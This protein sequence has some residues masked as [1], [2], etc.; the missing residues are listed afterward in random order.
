ML[1]VR[2]LHVRYFTPRGAIPAVDGVAFGVGRGEIVGLVGESGCGKTTV[3][4]AILQTVQTPGR[5]TQGEVR[6]N[7]KNLIGLSEKMLRRLRWRTLSLVPQ[8]AM[9]SLNP[10][11]RIR[12]QMAD[13]ILTHE[14]IGKAELDRRIVG[15]LRDVGLPERVV[16][17]YPHELSG[18]MKQRICIAMAI[19]LRPAAIVA[20][21]PTSSLDVVVQRVVVQTLLDVKTRLGVSLLVISHDM[22]IQA[23]L[24]DRIAVMYA[25]H[26]VETAPVEAA[27]ARPLHPYTQLLI[28]SIPSIRERSPVPVSE[29]LTDDL[30]NLPTGFV[31]QQRCGFVKPECHARRPSLTEIEKDHF[32]ACWMYEKFEG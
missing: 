19:A 21:E 1:E 17:L 14:H 3:A 11:L 12:E 8:G 7:G 30:R 23:Q 5:I 2:D 20:D 4:M 16:S 25:G 6:I 28:A 9:N 27:Y 32:V 13:A 31:F 15:L 26:L 18:G 10:V 24:A 22:G 29:G